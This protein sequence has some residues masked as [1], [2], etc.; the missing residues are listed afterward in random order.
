LLTWNHKGFFRYAE[1]FAV[2][3]RENGSAELFTAGTHGIQYVPGDMR[4]FEF[5]AT[6]RRKVELVGG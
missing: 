6:C 5:L 2:W 4:S 1:G 3:V